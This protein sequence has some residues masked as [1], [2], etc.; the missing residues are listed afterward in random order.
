MDTEYL[1]SNDASYWQAV[2]GV[3]KSFPNFDVT[4]SFAFVVEAVNYAIVSVCVQ[5]ARIRGPYCQ[6]SGDVG[7]FVIAS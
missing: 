1:S 4:T 3:D 6:T 7:A 5:E 2:E